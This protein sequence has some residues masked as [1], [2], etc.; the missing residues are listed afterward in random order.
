MLLFRVLNKEV[1]FSCACHKEVTTSFCRDEIMKCN[2]SPVQSYTLIYK[3]EHF[4]CF[5][6][7]TNCLQPYL[8]VIP[9]R[10]YKVTHFSDKEST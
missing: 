5:F 2:V 8:C 7:M 1:I 10:L 3:A 6:C 4:V 9:K